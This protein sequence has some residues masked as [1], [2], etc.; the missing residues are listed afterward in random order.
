M[1]EFTSEYGEVIYG[2]IIFNLPGAAI[3]AIWRPIGS[4]MFEFRVKLFDSGRT[5]LCDTREECIEW[6]FKEYLK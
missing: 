1:K 2:E 3:G 4:S 6:S 5:I